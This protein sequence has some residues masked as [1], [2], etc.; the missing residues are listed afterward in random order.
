[1]RHHNRIAYKTICAAKGGDNEAMSE[2]LR[3]Y[4]RYIAYFS[5][6]QLFDE[7]G[8]PREAV[9]EEIK[10]MITS[11]YMAAIFF[12]YDIQRLPKEETQEKE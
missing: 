3:H 2:I 7:Y 11:E 4:D 12:Q 10:Q 9:D 5:K 8:N 1:M 6:R